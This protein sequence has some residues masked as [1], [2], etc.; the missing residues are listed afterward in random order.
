MSPLRSVSLLIFFE[1]THT[2]CP[3]SDTFSSIKSSPRKFPPTCHFTFNVRPRSY[4]S[5][6][7]AAVAPGHT[8]S[9][10]MHDPC[11]SHRVGR[12]RSREL[13]Q[14][15]TVQWDV[16]AMR[17]SSVPHAEQFV[18]RSS[19]LLPS[20]QQLF[21]L[22]GVSLANEYPILSDRHPDIPSISDSDDR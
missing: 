6:A 14:R 10:S 22:P 1:E 11:E 17:L 12:L 20:Q 21:T 13:L 3:R 19:H 7:A 4:D 5:N 8:T 15:F 16:L 9:C 18:V 2:P